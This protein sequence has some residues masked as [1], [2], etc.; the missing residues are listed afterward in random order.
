M[1]GGHDDAK[2]VEERNKKTEKRIN[3]MDSSFIW[4]TGSDLTGLSGRNT[5]LCGLTAPA[6]C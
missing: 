3:F 1:F 4:P 6:A 2:A 5:W